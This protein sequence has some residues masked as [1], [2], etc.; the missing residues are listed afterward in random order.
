MKMRKEVTESLFVSLVDMLADV[1]AE[2]GSESE[3]VPRLTEIIS[4]EYEH[5][6]LSLCEKLAKKFYDEHYDDAYQEA[7]ESFEPSARD[8]AMASIQQETISAIN[9]G[10]Y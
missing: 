2:A 5:I 3:I 9:A 6:P 8:E 7:K 1:I 4:E 10:R